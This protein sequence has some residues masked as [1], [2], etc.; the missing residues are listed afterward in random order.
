MKPQSKK[1]AKR[2]K[3]RRKKLLSERCLDK[4]N[5]IR[6]VTSDDLVINMQKK[7][8]ATTRRTEQTMHDHVSGRETNGRD[9][10]SKELEPCTRGV[11]KA[12]ECGEDDI[13]CHL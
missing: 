13:P 1:V 10:I 7:K 4:G 5:I 9:H 11:F 8:I 6:V 12:I 2:T 3:I